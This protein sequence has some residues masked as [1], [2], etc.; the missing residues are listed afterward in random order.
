M[1]SPFV[2]YVQYVQYVRVL[3]YALG[4]KVAFFSKL[5]GIAALAGGLVLSNVNASSSLSRVEIPI[6]FDG[7]RLTV[8]ATIGSSGPLT[9]G[10]DTGAGGI[11]VWSD[12]LK[13]EELIRTGQVD[14]V[15]YGSGKR[16]LTGE[17]VKGKVKIGAF[18]FPGKTAFQLITGHI[19]KPGSG[20]GCDE[21]GSRRGYAGTLGIRPMHPMDAKQINSINNPFIVEGSFSY[22]VQAPK[23]EG[24]QGRLIV[25]P[26][27]SE[28]ARFTPVKLSVGNGARIPICIN[29]FCYDGIL[30]TGN[31]SNYIPA[32]TNRELNALGLPHDEKKIALGTPIPFLIGNG[33]KSLAGQLVAGKGS[34]A[35]H[36]TEANKGVFGIDFFKSFD[37][38]YDHQSATIGIA[39][40]D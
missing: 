32:G 35:F 6:V 7:D 38:Y 26:T 36:L 21:K 3:Q 9:L 2:Q 4:V 22:I 10:I 25:N 23:R 17:I 18:E 30:D 34:A 8:Q 33:K 16:G 15:M 37:V 19:C 27:K 28:I 39:F 11:R 31:G 29:A 12:H 20:E 24:E 1:E 40:K 5:L 13:P 14:N